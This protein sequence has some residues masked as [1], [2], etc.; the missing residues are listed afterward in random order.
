LLLAEHVCFSDLYQFSG[1]ASGIGKATCV[2]FASE[3]ASVVLVDINKE[4]LNEVFELLTKENGDK[5]MQACGNVADSKFAI[6]LFK[7]VT[8]SPGCVRMCYIRS[9]DIE[10][11][12]DSYSCEL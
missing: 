12:S 8:V 4:S 7:N 2:K 11:A 9:H 3:G 1:A 5:Y 10:K 6:E